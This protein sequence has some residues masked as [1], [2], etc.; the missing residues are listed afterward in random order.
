MIAITGVAHATATTN[1]L[2]DP[3]NL[4]SGNGEFVR[5]MEGRLNGLE[6][7]AGIRMLIRYHTQ[8]PPEAEDNEPGAFMRAL[9]SQLGV[10]ENGLLAVYF[11]DVDEWRVW[12]GNELTSRFVGKEGTAAEFTAS[13]AMHDAKEAWL[14]KVFSESEGVWNW[15]KATSKGKAKASDKVEFETIALSDGVERK[16]SP[17]QTT[18]EQ[19]E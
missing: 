12:I 5:D 10:L 16:F 6:Q 7:K 18:S 8:E 9:S 2:H 3:A 13:G 17:V 4:V 11:A 15:W 19:K 1:H 14:T